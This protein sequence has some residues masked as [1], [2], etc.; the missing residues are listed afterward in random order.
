MFDWETKWLILLA[1]EAVW[2]ER[3]SEREQG[4]GRRRAFF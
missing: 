1:V 4:N 3:V 2:R